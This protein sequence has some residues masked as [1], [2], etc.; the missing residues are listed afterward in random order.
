MIEPTVRPAPASTVEAFCCDKP[1]TLGTVA[2]GGPD[3]TTKFTAEPR[4][5]AAPAAGFW[6]MTVPAGTVELVCGVTLPTVRPALLR[7]VAAAL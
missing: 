3:D 1:T 6:L 4:A 2:G 5:T 7:A